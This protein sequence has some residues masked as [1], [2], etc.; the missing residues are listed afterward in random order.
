MLPHCLSFWDTA[1]SLNNLGVFVGMVRESSEETAYQSSLCSLYYSHYLW[2]VLF[3][4]IMVNKYDLM[5]TEKVRGMDFWHINEVWI[6]LFFS[7]SS[8]PSFFPLIRLLKNVRSGLYLFSWKS[9]KILVSGLCLCSYLKRLEILY[10][11]VKELFLPP[12]LA[13]NTALTKPNQI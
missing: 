7:F 6:W 11:M 1:V 8:P 4:N 5:L 2:K 10:F 13:F 3:W 9:V 12:V